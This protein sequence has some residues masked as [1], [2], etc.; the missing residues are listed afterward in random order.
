MIVGLAFDAARAA[1]VEHVV[2]VSS[3]RFP[4]AFELLVERRGPADC[5]GGGGDGEVRGGRGEE[6]QRSTYT[7]GPCSSL[8]A[9]PT[10]PNSD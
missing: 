6:R 5:C 1:D 4:C 7:C 10:R 2:L 8:A 3:A 9:H